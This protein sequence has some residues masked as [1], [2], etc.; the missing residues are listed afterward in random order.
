MLGKHHT[1]EA[2]EKIRR[3]VTGRHHTTESKA[4]LSAAHAGKV[5]S[6]DHRRKLSDAHAGKVLTAEHR[7]KIAASTTGRK[8]VVC[9]ETGKVF[10]SITAAARFLKVT[11]ASVYQSLREGLRCKGSHYRIA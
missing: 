7:A 3:A 10:P 5:L 8:P 4:K 6:D 9:V 2:R 1:K 11:E